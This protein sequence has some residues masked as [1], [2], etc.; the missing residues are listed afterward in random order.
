M[1]IHR[2]EI[3]YV[4]KVHP[5]A[6]RIGL[7]AR[8]ISKGAKP[9]QFYM[10]RTSGGLDPLLPRPF[11][12]H[13]RHLHGVEEELVGDGLEIFVQ[14]V[15]R[16]TRFLSRKPSGEMIDVIGPLGRGWRLKR[17]DSP[18]LVAG[19]IGVATFVALAEDMP[20]AQRR[21]TTVFLGA[22]SPDELWCVEDLE[23]CGLEVYTAAERGRHVFKGTAFDLLT[24]N[25]EAVRHKS[26]SLLV[27]GPP[28]MLKRVAAWAMEEGLPCQVSLEAPMACGVGVCLGCA[29]KASQSSSYLRVCREGPVMDAGEIDWT[30][31]DASLGA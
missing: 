27:C 3:R 4:I 30:A 19:G 25:R 22:Q 21:R 18:V 29:V 5:Q 28:P 8:G 11:A 10:V 1:K 7:E 31:W 24:A 13:R 15:G 16:G 6:Y 9:G 20:E 12:L 14:V 2:A 23:R 26:C 17:Q